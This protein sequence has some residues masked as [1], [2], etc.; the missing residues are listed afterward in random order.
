M[1]IDSVQ[2]TTQLLKGLIK[3][4]NQGAG[5]TIS[6]FVERNS[7]I[8]GKRF[9]ILVR[10]L[11]F[12]LLWPEGGYPMEEKKTSFV[13][14]VIM[15]DRLV[16]QHKTGNSKYFKAYKQLINDCYKQSF[17]LRELGV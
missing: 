2:R 14:S 6:G 16:C 5:S 1:L 12:Q 17:T 10:K 13:T 11:L 3:E 9:P 7:K 8:T 15:S 4:E